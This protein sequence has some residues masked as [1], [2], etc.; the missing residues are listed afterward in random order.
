MACLWMWHVC[1]KD[2]SMRDMPLRDTYIKDKK[3]KKTILVE[4]HVYE[5]HTSLEKKHVCDCD[6]IMRKTV[7]WETFLLEIHVWKLG[8]WEIVL[9]SK[10]TK[11]KTHLWE[12]HVYESDMSVIKIWNILGTREA[13]EKDKLIT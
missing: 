7:L 3:K 13:Y 5:L 8:L 1:E 11:W 12:I 9:M 4:R 6:S 2:T 10:T